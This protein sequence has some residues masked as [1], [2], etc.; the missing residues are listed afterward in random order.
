[1]KKP[2]KVDN[3]LK[4]LAISILETNE[5]S[6][7]EWLNDQY[8]KIVIENSKL[9]IQGLNLKRKVGNE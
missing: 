7:E 2:T 4:E 5:I 9:L 1:M 6:H 8:Q 3:D